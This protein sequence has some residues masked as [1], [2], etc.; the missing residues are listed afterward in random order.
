[1]RYKL[2]GNSGLRVSELCLGTMTFGEE[3]WGS[4]KEESGRV[5]QAFAEAGGNFVDTAD[6]YSG[7]KSERFLGELLGEDR[8]SFVVATKYTLARHPQDPNATGNHRKNLVQ[9]LD[10]SL[11]RL[12]T[13]YV[14]VL[15]VHQWDFFTPIE[16]VMRAL[17]DQ[18]R[19]GKV[20]Y[21]GI[22]DTPAWVVARANTMAEAHG[23]TP[24]VATQA[25]YS[26]VERT[27]ERELVPM[28]QALDLATTAWSPLGMGVLTGKYAATTSPAEGRLANSQ[29]PNSLPERNLE[30]A[31]VVGEVAAELGATPAQLALAWLMSRP[32]VVIPVVG[33]R[34]ESQLK[35]NLGAVDVKLNRDQLERLDQVSA[36]ELGF[37]HDFLMAM[38]RTNYVLGSTLDRIDNHRASRSGL[39]LN[40]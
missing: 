1:V 8:D 10:A 39:P 4:S 13:D 16:E 9:A 36:I 5:L 35:E 21:V 20:L 23:W 26:L 2:L 27:V 30:I 25:Q 32:G 12:G 22:S 14:D 31:R 29:R 7:G 3:G 34:Q 6:F 40:Q 17:D 15:W 28:A 37:P 19:A 24:F 38:R 33:A 11:K 18:V